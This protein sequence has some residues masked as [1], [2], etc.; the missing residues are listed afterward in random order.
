MATA[1]TRAILRLLDEQGQLPVTA[2]AESLDRHPVT[3]D[4][5]CYDLQR[6][7]YIRMATSGGAYALT[8]KG[9]TRL[10]DRWSSAGPV[11]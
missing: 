1:P 8:E 10:S 7:G 9:R 11:Q 2:I 4:R 3:V 6:D 5:Q